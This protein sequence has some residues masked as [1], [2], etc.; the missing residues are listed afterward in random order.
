M[1]PMTGN[2]QEPACDAQVTA[3]IRPQRCMDSHLP[4]HGLPFQRALL[5]KAGRRRGP[6]ELLCGAGCLGSALRRC[7]ERA[8]ITQELTL[9]GL[10]AGPGYILGVGMGPVC[11]PLPCSTRSEAKGRGEGW[12]G[13]AK[14]GGGLTHIESS[15]DQVRSCYFSSHFEDEKA[16][17]QG[18]RGCT[19]CKD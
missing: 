17:A 14:S 11:V 6:W 4:L 8:L 2:S 13:G 10:H 16:E 1:G 12:G 3:E 19:A 9:M 7:T 18:T 5:G 15:Q